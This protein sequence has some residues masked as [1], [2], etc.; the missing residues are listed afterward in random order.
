MRGAY[1]DPPSL[2]KSQQQKDDLEIMQGWLKA[3]CDSHAA[4]TLLKEIPCTLDEH[5]EHC[6]TVGRGCEPLCDLLGGLQENLCDLATCVNTNGEI[7]GG[8][9]DACPRCGGSGICTVLGDLGAKDP[10]VPDHKRLLCFLE[11]AREAHRVTSGLIRDELTSVAFFEARLNRMYER[12]CLDHDIEVDAVKLFVG[13]HREITQDGALPV[14]CEEM[15]ELR[16]LKPKCEAGSLDLCFW[17]ETTLQVVSAVRM[18]LEGCVKLSAGIR[19]D[20]KRWHARCERVPEAEEVFKRLCLALHFCCEEKNPCANPRN[21]VSC[22]REA[23]QHPEAEF[24]GGPEPVG[25]RAR[26]R[27]TRDKPKREFRRWLTRKVREFGVEPRGGELRLLK[28][29]DSGLP[30]N[31]ASIRVLVDQAEEMI[32]Q[33]KARRSQDKTRAYYAVGMIFAGDTP[34][35]PFGEFAVASDISNLERELRFSLFPVFEPRSSFREL[36]ERPGQ[37]QV[38]QNQKRALDQAIRTLVGLQPGEPGGDSLGGGPQP[39]PLVR[40]GGTGSGTGGGPG[41]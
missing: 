41:G 30:D 9:P 13:L 20:I 1:T 32:E 26:D 37:K 28:L 33:E 25:R 8:R 17:I 10:F 35:S 3:C 24:G 6:R 39:D 31:E 4:F 16:C 21:F 22:L 14:N 38:G 29:L 11:F 40:Q 19:K 27:Y 2:L 34:G 7:G 15:T 18:R 5:L 36:R 23:I 12:N